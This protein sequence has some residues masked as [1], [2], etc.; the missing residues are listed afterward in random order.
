[1]NYEQPQFR[2]PR[3]KVVRAFQRYYGCED[4]GLDSAEYYFDIVDSLYANG[5][6]LW[7]VIF[8]N[9]LEDIKLDDLGHHWT[10]RYNIDRVAQLLWYYREG[11]GKE[12]TIKIIVAP[13]S[14]SV[15]GVDI[16]GNVE[17]EEVNV[18]EGGIL[19]YEIY[20]SEGQLVLSGTP[21]PHAQAA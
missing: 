18:I 13:K 8:V 17:E 16:L 6:E 1:M 9:T 21:T 15:A 2:V 4:T 7:R 10:N 14:I 5:G 19:S 11:A 12:F 3:E 20:D